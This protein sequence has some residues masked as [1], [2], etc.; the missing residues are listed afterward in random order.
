MLKHLGLIL[1]QL[2]TSSL[3]FGILAK[4]PKVEV[5]KGESLQLSCVADQVLIVCRHVNNN[6]WKSLL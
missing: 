4:D 2:V 5:I 1:L 6:L 3:A